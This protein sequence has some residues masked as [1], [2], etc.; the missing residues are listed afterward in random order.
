MP[1]RNG[2]M[3]YLDWPERGPP[4]NFA[5]ANGFN[6]QTYASILAPLAGRFHLLA[7]DL[8]GHGL[9][10]L[11]ATA[12][13]SAGWTIFRDDLLEYLG[14]LHSGPVIL[15]GHSMGAT[16]SLMAAAMAPERVRA[17]V[18]FEP[19]LVTRAQPVIADPSPDLASRAEKR[20]ARFGSVEEALAAYR[21]RGIFRSWSDA[22]IA[23]YLQGG[24]R[25]LPDGT[26]ALACAPE[27]EAECFRQTPMNVARLVADVRCPITIAHGTVNSTSFASEIA[28]SILARP[29]ARVVSVE[30]AGHFL[31]MERPEI[32]CGEIARMGDRL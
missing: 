2:A 25:P 1:L 26:F 18:L 32:V 28:A 4:L 31:P 11:P 10:T 13:L 5:H 3:S 19:V 20:R 21:G 6:A 22:M 23:D 30:G 8:R 27:W 24:L 9:S 12:G 7:C 16:T 15:A 14:A 29:D 17:L